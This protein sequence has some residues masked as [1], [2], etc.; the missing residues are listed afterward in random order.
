MSGTNGKASTSAS[1]ELIDQNTGVITSP[2]SMVAFIGEKY[3]G[4]ST[5]QITDE[6]MKILQEPVNQLDVDIRPD[7]LI[8]LP[9]VFV[10]DRL[11]KAFKPG[12]WA[13]IEEWAKQNKNTMMFKGSLYIKGHFVASAIGEMEY[14]ENNSKMS[15]ASV[16]E[17]SKSD[18]LSR[19]AKDLGIGKECWMPVFRRDWIAKYA[20]KVWRTKV[21]DGRGEFQWRHIDSLP[22][23]D[24]GNVAPDSPNQPKGKPVQP[25]NV[26][27]N[28]APAKSKNNPQSQTGT[29]FKPMSDAQL[30][31]ELA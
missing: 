7:G 5:L 23:Y 1:I 22:F 13:L 6:E 31:K 29:A 12:G 28:S 3:S 20:I 10:R 24:E 21:K 30:K 26:N 14:H 18:C 2:E 17:G 4:A 8:Y 11:N 16:Y 9:Q 27:T 15:W 19:A 25:T